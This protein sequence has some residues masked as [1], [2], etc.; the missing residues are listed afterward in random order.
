MAGAARRGPALGGGDAGLSQ[1]HHG[2]TL[3]LPVN[4]PGSTQTQARPKQKYFLDSTEFFK[5]SKFLKSHPKCPKKVQKHQNKS[6]KK[7]LTWSVE[8]WTC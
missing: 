4:P 2:V 1:P 5:K 7:D 3:P 6:Q 8:V